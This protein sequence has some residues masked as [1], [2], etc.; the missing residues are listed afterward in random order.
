MA[1]APIILKGRVVDV[2]ANHCLDVKREE[3]S[4]A[5]TEGDIPIS[6]GPDDSFS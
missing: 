5:L 3:A 2:P 1:L 6:R 4:S